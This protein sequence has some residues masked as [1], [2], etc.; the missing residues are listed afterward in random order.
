M[1]D[2]GFN[3]ELV[4]GLDA[5]SRLGQF[6]RAGVLVAADVHVA[7]ALAR[8]GGDDDELVALAVALAVRAPRVGHVL[9]DL[10]TIRETAVAGFEEEADL[11]GLPWP[12]VEMWL[13]RVSSSPLV[14]PGNDGRDDRPLRLAGTS[15]YLDRYWQDEQDVAVRLIARSS[16]PPLKVDDAV[17]TVGLARLYP[18]DA[19]GLQSR[20]ADIVLHH[21]L[22]VIA[23][24]PGTGKT[25]TVARV[26]ALLAEQAAH[27]SRAFPTVA[28]VAPTGKAAAR[29]AEAVHD[30][31]RRLDVEDELRAWLLSLDASTVHRLLGRRAGTETRF[32]HDRHNQLPYE[33]VMVDETSMMSLPL[34]ARLLEAV[35]PDARLVL[36]GD[37]EQLASV[38]AGAVLGDIVGP[39]A[40]AGSGP[41]RA[42][43][44]EVAAS[45]VATSAV[46]TSA[47]ATSAV[48]AG[49]VEAKAVEAGPVAGGPMG[50]CITVLQAN[51]R[52]RGPLAELAQAVRSGDADAVLAVLSAPRGGTSAS[53][54][55]WLDVDVATAAPTSLEPVRT[56]LLKAHRPM[57][58]AAAAGDGA[59]AL[60]ALGRLRLLCAHRDGPAGAATWNARAEQ[61]LADLGEGPPP[62]GGWYMGRPVIVTENDY[63]LGL[64]NGD[65]GA[66]V[67]HGEDNEI[68]GSLR[69]AF[70]RGAGVVAVSPARL[71]AV[72]TAFA[73]TVHRAQGS[74]FDEIVAL[75]P[76][77]SSRVL[78]RELLYTAVT[79]A[80][81]SVVL[82]GTEGSLRAAVGR[83]IARASGLTLR[84][85]GDCQ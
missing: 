2:D 36:I 70:R 50:D 79:R 39:A 80:R 31:A 47:V 82:V 83:P 55:R 77:A 84:L 22:A 1:T 60:D 13:D 27:A 46:A 78:T 14:A 41:T 11:A 53:S 32:R 12:P 19:S 40:F 49:G 81:R 20:A 65:T 54:V 67:A 51:Y 38:E 29:M 37:Q 21:L 66:V 42:A 68:G 5:G 75:L 18:D 9:V 3:A 63:G 48:R 15:L 23:G 64:F 52:F 74:E 59:T 76:G 34:M 8:L 4:L 33:V 45:A 6:N 28:L 26:L 10:A 24:G 71:G 7:R 43:A 85:W 56:A 16:A 69:V 61:W 44:G 17:L 62:E 35:R 57:V 58:E 73:M 25:T 30:A 72:E